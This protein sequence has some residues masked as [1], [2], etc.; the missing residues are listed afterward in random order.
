M[1]HSLYVCLHAEAHL[2]FFQALALMN[3]HIINILLKFFYTVILKLKCHNID[4]K[5]L[6]GF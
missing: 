5:S 3:K 6:Q 2:G 1:Y 4:G